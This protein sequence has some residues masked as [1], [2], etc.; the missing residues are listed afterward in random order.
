MPRMK[1][2]G[3]FDAYLDDQSASNAAIIRALRRFVAREAP[4]LVESVKWGNGCWL[5][6]TGPVAYVYSDKDHVQFGFFMGAKLKDP[7]RLLQ[8]SGKYVRH[9]KLRAPSEIRRSD[10]AALLK[11]AVRTRYGS[12]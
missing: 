11:Q 5:G 9:A 7:K 1:A 3:S 10:L 4:T 6:K 8:G 12:G 2:Y